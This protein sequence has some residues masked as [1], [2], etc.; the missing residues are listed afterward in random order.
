MGTIL[1]MK[2]SL[3]LTASGLVP[4]RNSSVPFITQLALV[5]PGCTL[6]DRK[7]NGRF[8]EEAEREGERST[9]TNRRR[10]NVDKKEKI[11]Q[12]KVFHS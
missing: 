7:I 6:A 8:P 9:N 4:I 12:F 5:S 3:R 1:K 11:L 10:W 2:P